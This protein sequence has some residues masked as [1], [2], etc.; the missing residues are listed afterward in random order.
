MMKAFAYLTTVILIIVGV[1]VSTVSGLPPIP[2]LHA[3]GEYPFAFSV[4]WPTY[5]SGP[6]L[7]TV[8]RTFVFYTVSHTGYGAFV[9]AGRTDTAVGRQVIDELSSFYLAGQK[10]HTSSSRG[11][12]ITISDLTCHNPHHLPL[13]YEV[14]VVRRGN[15]T[16]VVF[17]SAADYLPRLA[18][19][20]VNS[21][22]LPVGQPPL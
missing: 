11:T 10:A 4:A 19:D 21:F 8:K 7:K 1:G 5:E 3:Y 18:Q 15:V 13:C 9:V 17:A 6:I 20:F 14:E 22:R 2:V 16:W 12:T